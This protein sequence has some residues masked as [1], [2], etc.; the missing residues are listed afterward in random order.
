MK[1]KSH[2]R[3]PEKQGFSVALPKKLVADIQ[4][5]AKSETRSRN[6]QIE[7]FLEDSVAAYF[8]RNKSNEAVPPQNQSRNPDHK[9]PDRRGRDRRLPI[10]P[11]PQQIGGFP[12]PVPPKYNL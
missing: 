9:P 10:A 1:N 6:R 7:K 4:K 8:I 3:S 11:P 12:I 2:D 5:I